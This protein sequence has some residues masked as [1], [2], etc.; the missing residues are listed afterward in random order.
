MPHCLLDGALLPV[1][2]KRMYVSRY[3]FFSEQ[4]AHRLEAWIQGLPSNTEGHPYL[5][6]LF[7]WQAWDTFPGQ[8][9]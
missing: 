9:Q 2:R 4:W 8:S 5:I 3:S 7:S 1:T 6:V